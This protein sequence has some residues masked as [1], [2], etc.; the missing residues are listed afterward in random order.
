MTYNTAGKDI[1]HDIPHDVNTLLSSDTSLLE[2]WQSLTPLAQNEWICWII[3]PKKPETRA[4]HITR[5]S[6]ELLQGKRRPCCW[7]GCP[8]RIKR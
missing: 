3:S 5:M 6:T 1:A 4:A 8:H 7:P 2:R